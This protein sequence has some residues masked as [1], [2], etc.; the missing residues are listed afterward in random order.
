MTETKTTRDGVTLKY[1][2]IKFRVINGQKK[3]LEFTRKSSLRH[4]Q[5]WPAEL[6]RGSTAKFR[7]GKQIAPDFFEIEQTTLC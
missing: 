5:S 7:L 4:R 2:V 6:V 3:G 1:H